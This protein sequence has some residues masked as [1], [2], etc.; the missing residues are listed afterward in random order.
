MA[1]RVASSN[2]ADLHG[3]YSLLPSNHT[4][5]HSRYKQIQIL[6]KIKGNVEFRDGQDWFLALMSHS[7]VWAVV[8]QEMK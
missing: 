6:N 8:K 5:I 7:K 2:P 4:V 1:I 3:Q